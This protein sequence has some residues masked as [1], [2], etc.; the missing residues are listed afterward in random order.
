M[1]LDPSSFFKYNVTDACS[2]WNILSSRVLYSAAQ[3]AKCTFCCT[4]YVQYECLHKKRSTISEN[5]NKLKCLLKSEQ[6]KGNFSRYHL[7][8]EDLLDIEILSARMNLGKGE[9]SS[10][11]FARRTRQGFLT[12]DQKARKLAATAIDKERIQTTPH[13]FGWLTY[14]NFLTDGDKDQVINQ[15]NNFG[16][17]LKEFFETMYQRALEFRLMNST[18]K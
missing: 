1:P 8:I 11:A 12:D 15:H 16:R 17:P 5:E 6:E 18:K 14:E 13:L 2:I 3:S 7:D 9:L 10:I 4:A